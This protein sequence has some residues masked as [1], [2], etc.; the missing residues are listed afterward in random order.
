M[1][2]VAQWQST[3]LPSQH[4]DSGFDPQV[5]LGTQEAEKQKHSTEPKNKTT[6][7]PNSVPSDKGST[8][9]HKGE[10]GSQPPPRSCRVDDQW[11]LEEG[12]LLLLFV[13]LRM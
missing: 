4:K 8:L 7:Q 1:L 5:W 9:Q 11:L 2:G 6:L 13:C 10:E 3:Y 12:E